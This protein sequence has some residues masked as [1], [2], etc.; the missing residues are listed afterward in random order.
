MRKLRCLVLTFLPEC[1]PCLG[2]VRL[3]PRLSRSKAPA[4]P[5]RPGLSS[6]SGSV[7]TQHFPRLCSPP[8]SS[9]LLP[10]KMLTPVDNTTLLGW[11]LTG[12]WLKESEWSTFHSQKPKKKKMEKHNLAWESNRLLFKLSLCHLLVLGLPT[13]HLTSLS[14]GSLF[15]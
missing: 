4:S 5:W 3:G 6:C 11:K 1:R 8:L 2:E 13:R 9:S 10:S 14:V 15:C 7:L 12:L